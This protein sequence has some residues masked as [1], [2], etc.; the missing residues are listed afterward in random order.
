[1]SN[2]V[3]K[4]WDSYL[5]AV[6]AS[7]VPANTAEWYVK[8]SEKFARATR[9]KSLRE[10]SAADIRKF[11]F[12][13][14]IQRGIQPWQLQQAEEA[15]VFLYEGFLKVD[16]GDRYLVSLLDP[17][18]EGLHNPSLIFDGM[19]SGKLDNELDHG[20]DHPH[21]RRIIRGCRIYRRSADSKPSPQNP[22]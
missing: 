4:F 14:S 15:L 22:A 8:W 16:F 18:F 5:Q 11:L 20:N 2:N 6:I 12:E 9:G 7:G 19:N 13:L 17:I 10:R 1:M 3:K 21:P